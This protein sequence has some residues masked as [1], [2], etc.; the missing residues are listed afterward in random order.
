MIKTEIGYTTVEAITVRGKNLANELI[1][2]ID[3]IDMIMLTS[4]A[5]MPSPEEKDMINAILVMTCD[6]GLTPSALAARLTYTGTPE[7]LQGAIAAGLLGA[8]S[9]FLGSQQNAAEM[10]IE[11]VSRLPENP[12][13]ADYERVAGEFLKERRAQRGQLF[14][15]GHNLHVDGD[16]RI[17]TM[18]AISERNGFAGKHWKMLY[19]LFDGTEQAYGRKLVIN[20]AGAVGAMVAD[21]GLPVLMSRGLSLV[22]RCAGLLAHVLEEVQNPTGIELWHLVLEQDSR[23]DVPKAHQKAK[24]PAPVAA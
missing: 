6:H 13:D 3:F 1:G 10:L 9:V 24:A 22:S 18:Y 20:A 5:R 14:G 7:A 23:N 19:A 8:G 17:P 15:F 4:L 16:P 11:V 21:M 2:K 12:S